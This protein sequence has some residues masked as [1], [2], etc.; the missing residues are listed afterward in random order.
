VHRLNAGQVRVR[1]GETEIVIPGATATDGEVKVAVCPE[2]IVVEV[3]PGPVGALPGVIGKATYLGT[4]MEYTIDTGA[5]TLFA[6]C[7]R[8]E[9][10]LS[11]GDVVALV[12]A[13][14]GDIIV[15][16]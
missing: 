6:T 16:D 9:R 8:V 3:L 14:R 1:L 2:A 11:Q 12:L 15:N 13:Q 7:P 5:G 10:P 4:H